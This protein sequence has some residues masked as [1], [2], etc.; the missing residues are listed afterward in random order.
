MG[1]RDSKIIEQT[2]GK[3]CRRTAVATFQK[4]TRQDA[5]PQRDLMEPRPMLGRQMAHRLLC[6]VAQE[7]AALHASAQ[8]LGVIGEIAPRGYEA[9]HRQAPVRSESIDHPI[10]ACHGGELPVDVGER[11]RQ[12]LTGA[13]LAQRPPPLAGRHHQGGNQDASPMADIFLLTFGWCA[14]VGRWRGLCAL[15]HLQARLLVDPDDQAPRLAEAQGLHR[16]G[17]DGASLGVKL[18]IRAMQPGDTPMRF[19]RGCVEPPPEGRTA[20]RPGSGLVAAHCR[21][22]LKAPARHW[23]VVVCRR[24]RRE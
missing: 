4:A 11:R 7:G 13:G 22:V 1:V 17:T 9:A 16:E 12:V 19:E 23:A 15:E 21:H 14:W 24:T 3:V 20:P 6:W 5:Q 2:G 10:R 8:G 18:W